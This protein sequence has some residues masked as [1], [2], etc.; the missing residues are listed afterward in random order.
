MKLSEL[1]VIVPTRNEEKNIPRFLASVP[2]AVELIVVDASE[3][4]TVE[5]LKRERRSPL[6]I[7]RY[8]GNISQARQLG[9]DSARTP[10]L[11]FSDADVEFPP[12]YF[13]RV[14]G[15]EDDDVVY[16]PKLSQDSY[17]SYYQWVARTQRVSHSLGLPA[18]S[19][20]NL[21]VRREVLRGA[22]GFDPELACNEDSEFAWRAKRSGFRVAFDPAL[23]VYARD[24]RRL[25]RGRWRKTAHSIVRCL[26]L[27]FDLLPS[28]WRGH[29]W[30]Y[31][32]AL[33]SDAEPPDR[34]NR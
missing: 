25:H 22:G 26:A 8:Y 27:Y 30:G 18:A 20:S 16:G 13:I 17:I 1:T 28:R 11:L 21:L 29:D 12:G 19:G 2:E 5:I 15:H 23:L 14:L 33:E 4:R 31:W 10:W 3:D 9:A 24:H 6:R 32:S 7:L 34:T